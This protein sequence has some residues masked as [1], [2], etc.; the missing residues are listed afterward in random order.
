MRLAVKELRGLIENA[1]QRHEFEDVFDEVLLAV[2]DIEGVDVEIDK[3]KHCSVTLSLDDDMSVIDLAAINKNV[4][5]ICNNILKTMTGEKLKTRFERIVTSAQQQVTVSHIYS[6]NVTIIVSAYHE[7][8]NAVIVR[9][10]HKLM[11][12][13]RKPSARTQRRN[14]KKDAAE[15]LTVELFEHLVQTYGADS[16]AYGHS[17]MAHA[18]LHVLVKTPENEDN[19]ALMKDFVKDIAS[20]VW[21]TTGEKPDVEHEM[22]RCH[23]DTASFSVTIDAGHPGWTRSAGHVLPRVTEP[24]EVIFYVKIRAR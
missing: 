16:V 20:V 19:Y 8:D 22:P 18:I 24:N 21:V 17:H 23:C 11:H 3:A 2:S 10:Q 5:E 15:L 9:V 1:S 13:A 6:Q 4:F 7:Q 14:K 12:E